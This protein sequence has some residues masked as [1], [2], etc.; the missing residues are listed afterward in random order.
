MKIANIA[1]PFLLDAVIDE[2]ENY[3][4]VST[5]AVLS[6]GRYSKFYWQR[7]F[8]GDFVI[9]NNDAWERGKAASIGRIIEAALLIDPKEIVLPDYPLSAERTVELAQRSLPQF[10][11]AGFRDFMAVPHGNS[12]D[13]WLWCVDELTKLPGVVSLGI[14][15]ADGI[16]FTGG[17]REKLIKSVAPFQRSIHLL[18]MSTDFGEIQ[19]PWVRQNVRGCDTSKLVRGGMASEF[20]PVHSPNAFSPHRPH[21]YLTDCEPVDNHAIACIK[22]NII[23]WRAYAAS[24]ALRE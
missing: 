23:Y 8:D 7:S 4:V 1:P 24:H 11:N 3:H 21:K 12:L 10:V 18:G 20:L 2:G 22:R 9:L 16:R 14:A 5:N 15:Y 13:E 6:D 19:S 17:N